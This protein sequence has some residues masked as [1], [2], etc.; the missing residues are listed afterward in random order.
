[1]KNS[2]KQTAGRARLARRGRA[3]ALG[4]LLVLALFAGA[5]GAQAL[6]IDAAQEL[7]NTFT[8]GR[9]T[10]AV[11]ET[12]DGRVKRDVRVKNTGNA[13]AYIRVA[14][15]TYLTGADGAVD[16]AQAAPALEFAPGEGWVLHEDGYYYYTQPVAPG[17]QT[18]AL[19]GSLTLAP[20]QVV[21]VIASAV[22]SAPA[23]AVADAWGVTI[24]P[25][26]VAAAG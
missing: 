7:P 18:G 15:V 6:L 5:A 11:E 1:M 12:F 2:R 4:A 20:G 24:A 9:V 21:D 17:A 14:L 23:R 13:D 8:P 25:G 10:C 3:A 26:S 16:G 19:I 22:Q